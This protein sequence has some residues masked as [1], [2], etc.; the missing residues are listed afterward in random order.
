MSIHQVIILVLLECWKHF[1][2]TVPTMTEALW[3]VRRST[4]TV[5]RNRSE[6]LREY[7]LEYLFDEA[8]HCKS[9]SVL[10]A[11]HHLM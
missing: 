8:L 4:M 2:A 6:D 7:R 1:A 3:D 11:E 10:A 9:G 5:L